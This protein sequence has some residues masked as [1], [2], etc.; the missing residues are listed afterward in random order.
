MMAP[1][2]EGCKIICL[3]EC[4][5]TYW[6]WFYFGHNSCKSKALILKSKEGG[7]LFSN[8]K[9]LFW[10]TSCHATVTS[11]APKYK[12]H[13]FV[14]D[15]TSTCKLM[16]LDSVRKLIVGCEAEELWDG[17]YDEIEDPTYLP[18][19]I[20][21][22]VGKSLCFGVTLSSENVANGSD[23]FLVSQVCSGDK[24][25]Q[26]ESNSDPMTHVMDGS[27]ITSGGEVW[28]VGLAK[29]QPQVNRAYKSGVRKRPRTDF[30]FPTNIS[31]FL[32]RLEEDLLPDT[33]QCEMI[34]DTS[35]EDAN[36]SAYDSDYA[37]RFD[38]NFQADLDC[39]S[40]E[41]TDSDSDPEIEVL[42]STVTTQPD[43]T[44]N[45]GRIKS[46][47]SLFEEAFSATEKPAKKSLPKEDGNKP[48]NH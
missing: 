41:N 28:I 35:E 38:E 3:I 47:A 17:S 15:D 45:R 11:V 43:N 26:I 7:I 44:L 34:G 5:D 31:N 22:L 33:F 19:P 20:R 46:L 4:M 27:S 30:Q 10:C 13:M 29:L 14:K 18:Q 25:L 39:S 48:L 36:P 24:I 8:E 40:K 6:S 23:V 12:L 1:V 9:P 16:M 32:D 21:D 42:D 37:D 2:E